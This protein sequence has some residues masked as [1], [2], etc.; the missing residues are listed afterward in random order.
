MSA[1][2]IRDG[3]RFDPNINVLVYFNLTKKCW[4]IV[5]SGIVIGYCDEVL[6]RDVTFVVRPAG[7]KKVLK[8]KKKNVHAYARGYITDEIQQ[9]CDVPVRYNPYL[10]DK[11]FYSDGTNVEKVSVLVMKKDG[12]CFSCKKE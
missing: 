10:F 6:L 1:I 7:R 2:S 5:Q 4:S 12:K 8:E 11:F 3:K 9:K